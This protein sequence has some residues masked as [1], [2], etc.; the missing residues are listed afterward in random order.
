MFMVVQAS[1]TPS[2]GQPDSQARLRSLELFAGGGG[3]ALGLHAAGFKHSALVE[4]D[5]K[6]CD[7]LRHNARCWATRVSDSKAWEDDAVMLNDVRHIDLD[8]IENYGSLDLLAGGPPCQP[9]SLGGIHA[10][11]NDSRNMFPAA[12]D[13]V[14]RCKPKLVLF[15][16]VAGLLRKSFAP[17]FDYVEMQLRDPACIP[18]A[19]ET[20]AEHA[21][22]LKDRFFRG[23]KPGY[24][25]TRQLV[26]AA[27]FGVPQIRKR[28]VLM[29]VRSDISDRPLPS[30]PS[31]H[32][33]ASLHYSQF[34]SGDYWHR[35]NLIAPPS[36][37]LSRATSSTKQSDLLA[38]KLK[39]WQTV[40]DAIAGLPDPIDGKPHP[41]YL[42][43]IGIPGARSYQGH[44]GSDID[45]PSK[46]I[47]AGV[48]GVCGGEAMIRFHDGDLRYM[49]VRESARIQTFPDDYEF[50]GARSHA[51][52][53]IGNAVPVQLATQIGLH[54]RF[55]SGM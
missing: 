35:H 32:S 49:T 19:G 42:N 31:T 14:R 47:K 18:R 8:C 4:F 24:Y 43:H 28:V 29:A 36:Q 46:T 39:P 30:I 15:E 51:M 40:R 54:M 6:A 5:P 7:T 33:E 16:N 11:M 55:H 10:G 44:T 50:L 12:L 20:W 1:P 53:H 23:Y 9:F 37:L 21:E 27:D 38:S 2:V 41:D 17:Y 48:H 25:I 34:V 3:M 45:S 26:N 52:R 13:L 22:R